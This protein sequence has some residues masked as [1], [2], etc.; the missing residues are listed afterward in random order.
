MPTPTNKELWQKAKARVKKR[1]KVWPSAYASGQLVQE[2]KK[3]GGTFQ[4]AKK[5]SDLARWYREKWVDVCAWPR[6]VECGRD[7]AT[8]GR[9]FPYCRPSVKVSADTPTTVQDLTL[10]QRKRLC[11]KKR[12]AP[13]E[14][15]AIQD[16]RRRS[17]R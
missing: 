9:A 8:K 17:H 7:T 2:Y 4:G 5:G 6:R 13:K 16:L 1:V 3:M 11:A 12:A 10:K 14:T 15:V